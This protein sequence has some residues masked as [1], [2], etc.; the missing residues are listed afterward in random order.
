MTVSYLRYLTVCS[1]LRQA[2]MRN[3]CTTLPTFKLVGLYLSINCS[4]IIILTKND[5]KRRIGETTIIHDSGEQDAAFRP[6]LTVALQTCLIPLLRRGSPQL[7]GEYVKLYSRVDLKLTQYKRSEISL[8]GHIISR[9]VYHSNRSGEQ[10][11][12]GGGG[13][14]QQQKRQRTSCDFPGGMI[15]FVLFCSLFE[16]IL[17][18]KSGKNNKKE[19]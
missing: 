8:Q 9:G 4:T 3:K 7:C 13:G 11:M 5:W 14:V 15:F 10:I 18:T 2:C 17:L 1:L 16:D 6:F 19:H 12:R